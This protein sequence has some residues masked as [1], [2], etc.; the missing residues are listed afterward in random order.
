MSLVTPR[1]K[2]LVIEDEYTIRNVL[3]ALLAGFDCDS[4]IA[5]SGRQAIGM[6][7][8]DS[9]DA[10]LLDLRS[11]SVPAEEMV[12]RIKQ[13][14]PS[15]VGRVLVISGEVT[16]PK[17]L[18]WLESQCLTPIGANNLMQEP[19]SRLRGIFGLA[20]SPDNGA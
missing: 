5:H 20:P 18:E 9:F 1:R 19:W 4:E 11:N 14:Q 8:R 6:I 12:A 10:V 15:L 13:L 2:I 16:D 7:A 17:T 3:Y